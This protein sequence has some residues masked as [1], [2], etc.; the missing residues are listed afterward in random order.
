MAV[1]KEDVIRAVAE[2]AGAGLI[3]EAKLEKGKWR[4]TLTKDDKTT[5]LELSRGFMEDYLEKGEYQQE[6]AFE[7][8]INKALKELKK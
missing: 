5:H 6:I 1:S 8:R 2:K 3:I 4:L 7:N